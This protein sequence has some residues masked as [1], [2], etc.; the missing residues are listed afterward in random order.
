MRIPTI[1]FEDKE[2]DFIYMPRR[3]ER[4]MRTGSSKKGHLYAASFDATRPSVVTS[5]NYA[6]KLIHTY[7]RLGDLRSELAVVKDLNKIL[8]F[9][10]NDHKGSHFD[11][12]TNYFNGELI[13]SDRISKGNNHNLQTSAGLELEM[14]T[15]AGI[16]GRLLNWV[17]IAKGKTEPTRGTAA[18]IDEVIRIPVNPEGW[19]TPSSDLLYTGVIAGTNTQGGLYKSAGGYTGN[20]ALDILGWVCLLP[21]SDYIQHN[22]GTTMMIWSHVEEVISLF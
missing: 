17:G 19:L 16:G 2:D 7:R 8:D 10:W 13:I 6:K 11:Y 5:L 1:P 18:L 9:N 3:E 4:T 14:M 21:E 12:N 20:T 22:E 15:K